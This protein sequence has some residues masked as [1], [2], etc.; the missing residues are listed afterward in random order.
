MQ[1][2]GIVCS[3]KRMFVH[4]LAALLVL[5]LQ[6]CGPKVL[7]GERVGFLGWMCGPRGA[8]E[9]TCPFSLAPRHGCTLSSSAPV[10]LYPSQTFLPP[11]QQQPAEGSRS[12]LLRLCSELPGPWGGSRLSQ[13]LLDICWVDCG[14]TFPACFVKE[15][16][17]RKD[18]WIILGPLP[19]GWAAEFV[20]ADLEE[21]KSKLQ[22]L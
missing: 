19:R 17:G 8:R 9:G 21:V 2:R 3:P 6:V 22:P 7:W 11:G 10:A 18:G 12:G 13:R 14:V 4:P 16:Q 15:L 20:L 1:T 5:R